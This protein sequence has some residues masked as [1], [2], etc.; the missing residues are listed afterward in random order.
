MAKR[1]PQ[2]CL[3]ASGAPT[4]RGP[5]LTVPKMELIAGAF[6][7]AKKDYPHLKAIGRSKPALPP[8]AKRTAAGKVSA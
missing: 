4:S 2:H 5:G 7:K 3:R 1:A 6:R 8:S